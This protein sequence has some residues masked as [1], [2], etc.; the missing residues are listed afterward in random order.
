MNLLSWLKQSIF[1]NDSSRAASPRKRQHR[2]Q[3]ETLED[4]I[5]PAITVTLDYSLDTNGFFNDQAR[6]QTLQTAV[7]AIASQLNDN[8]TAIVPGGGNTWSP[9][10]F[11]PSTGNTQV[12]NS[13]VINQ[14]EIR[15][16]VGGRAM[17]GSQAGEG[18][19]GGAFQISGSNNWIDTVLNRGQGN[20]QVAGAT[21]FSVW[22]GSIAFDTTT[23]WYFGTDP[24]GIGSNQ[25]SFYS[26]AQHEF[27]H[28]LG[29]GTSLSYE[30]DVSGAIL[31]GTNVQN[32]YGGPVPLASSVDIDHFA[33]NI[34][35][36][37]V[38]PALSPVLTQGD[39]ISF[40]AL[41]FAALA[42]IGWNVSGLG[43][44]NG[45]GGG[46][47]PPPQSPTPV[48]GS[49][50]STG[51]YAVGTETGNVPHVQVFN[52]DGSTR[53]SF[54]AY[55]LSMTAG[56]RVATGDINGDGFEDVIT[57]TGK[58]APPH[59]RAFD[60]RTGT[61]LRSFYAYDPRFLQGVFIAAGDV[62]G[63]GRADIITGAGAGGG[64]HVKV[65]SGA[66][67]GEILSTFAYDPGYLGGI[68]VAAGDV[69]GD[70]RADIITG[71]GV[72]SPPHVR[73][74]DGLSLAQY[75]SFFAYDPGFRGGLTLAA[76]DVNGDGAD[77]IITA[78]GAGAGPHVQA[79]DG[80]TNQT[81]VSFFA[82]PSTVT[83][84]IRVSAEDVNF[85]GR[86]DFVTGLGPGTAPLLTV[87]SGA[88]LRVLT[89]F[90]PYATGYLGGFMIG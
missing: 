39:F 78:A 53:F 16:Y 88:D 83:N 12:L 41:D 86:A 76:G 84:G 72:N 63:D 22:G 60:G 54:F 32:V 66:S 11:N 90:F 69:N 80:R 2:L 20:T 82:G 30:A 57:A 75:A 27:G 47:T 7:N 81:L 62:D 67:G 44:G 38:Q 6:R 74:F 33:Q 56:V 36:G 85:D 4:R 24:N 46:S 18:G 40:T 13:L 3:V 34:T 52:A 19:T 71:T 55:D 31:V 77:D 89:Q 21:D 26:V 25:L 42:D 70:G 45:G 51:I 59:I 43:G 68:V 50:V 58:G 49:V 64:P 5:T 35:S 65:F 17:P 87:Y 23:N 1:S 10:I 37:G 48:P 79:F 14:N 61:E 15:V 28:V 9:Q 29:F 8:L 73:A